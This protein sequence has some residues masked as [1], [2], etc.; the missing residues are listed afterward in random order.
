MLIPCK[1]DLAYAIFT[2]GSTGGLQRGSRQNPPCAC[3]AS[4]RW[5]SVRCPFQ[6]IRLQLLGIW[7]PLWE[8]SC[9]SLAS[10]T[11]AGRPKCVLCEPVRLRLRPLGTGLNNWRPRGFTALSGFEVLAVQ[12][13]GLS[14]FKFDWTGGH[15]PS[16]S[17]PQLGAPSRWGFRKA[18]QPETHNNP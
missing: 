15:V 9:E 8:K 3:L 10:S 16:S 11:H 1:E 5:P 2:S 18:S 4:N 14:G 17:C 6:F 13:S 12:G 7:S